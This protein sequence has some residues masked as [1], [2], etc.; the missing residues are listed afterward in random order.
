MLRGLSS[1]PAIACC[2][3]GQAPPVPPPAPPPQTEAE[4]TRQV[5]LTLVNFARSADNWKLPSCARAALQ[6]VLDHYDADHA[7]ARATLGWRKNKAGAW[8]AAAPSSPPA[9]DTA[10]PNQHRLVAEAWAAASRRVITLH[11]EFARRVASEGDRERASRHFRRVLA[12]PTTPRPIAASATRSGTASSAPP[13]RSRSASGCARCS[14]RRA[15]S[16]RCRST[17]PN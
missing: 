11:V 14:T 16:R 13:S 7:M 9:A 12:S 2:L 15:R 1:L 8:E 17:S 5:T 3:I 6:A 10:T 4:L